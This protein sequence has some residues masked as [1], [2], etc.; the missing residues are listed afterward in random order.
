MALAT[1]LVSMLV[2]ILLAFSPATV[3][4]GIVD[5]LYK[6]SKSWVY[7]SR[8]AFNSASEGESMG[9]F[10]ATFTYPNTSN[11]TLQVFLRGC[12]DDARRVARG[13]PLADFS[14]DNPASFVRAVCSTTWAA[15]T[16]TRDTPSL[17]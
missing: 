9:K 6:G 15:V 12:A 8:F 3:D 13:F 17:G 5:G 7:M 1:A 4:A 2:V 14:R 10:Q 11:P 16:T